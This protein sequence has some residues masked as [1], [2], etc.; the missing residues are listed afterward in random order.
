[1]YGVNV[2]L[3]QGGKQILSAVACPLLSMDAQ[4][5]VLD[6]SRDPAEEGS[7]PLRSTRSRLVRATL[8]RFPAEA[9]PRRI[10]QLPPTA[11]VASLRSVTCFDKLTPVWMM[12]TR[13][14][15]RLLVLTSPGV[16]YW[17]GFRDGPFWRW[18]WLTLPSGYTKRERVR[19]DMGSCGCHAAL[20]RNWW[21]D[22][23]RRREGHQFDSRPEAN[24]QFCA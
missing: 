10:A 20:R 13:P 6:H 14:S 16:T 3:L 4:Y 22:H 17:V 15:L 8:A 23:G 21:K 24:G 18:A 12:S 19:Q 2:C 5:P 1:M 9:Q 7:D 11:S